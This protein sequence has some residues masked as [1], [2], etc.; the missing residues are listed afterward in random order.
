[1]STVR[2]TRPP[3]VDRWPPRACEGTDTR[4]FFPGMDGGGRHAGLEAVAKRICGRCSALDECKAYALPIQDLRGV[5]AAMNE[6][7]RE[8]ARKKQQKEQLE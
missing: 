1:M 3:P 7:E 4:V 5:W 2:D 6:G 8:R